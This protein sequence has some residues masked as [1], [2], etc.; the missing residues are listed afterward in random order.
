MNR[1]RPF[2]IA[3][4]QIS[5]APFPSVAD[6]LAK[7]LRFIRLAAANHVQ[8]LVFPE[9]SLTGYSVEPSDEAIF[10]ITDSRLDELHEACCETIV[11]R[12]DGRRHAHMKRF[13]DPSET[14]SFI[15]GPSGPL[16]EFPHSNTHTEHVALAICADT[17]N[18]LHALSASRAGATL[19]AGGS[20]IS[21]TSYADELSRLA[22]YAK[23]Y[24]MA[25][26]LANH[27]DGRGTGGYE[28]KGGSALWDEKGEVI[29]RADE[30]K[31]E[32]LVIGR[33][34]GQG[35]WT[36]GVVPLL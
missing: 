30:S 16:L 28:A 25:V 10:Q 34:G 35:G 33:K 7:H 15:P 2:I 9:L 13:L 12:P 1:R 11:M 23:E 18:P 32:V 21:S 36:G 4:A 22:A 6:N 14:A 20:I 3:A 8:L 27:A 17:S 19:Y 24:G 26:L 5:V 31:D 29:V